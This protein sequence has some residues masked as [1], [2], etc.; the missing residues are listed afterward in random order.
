MKNKNLN[1]ILFVLLI[2][3]FGCI[4]IYKTVNEN[5][6]AAPVNLNT[7]L[8]VSFLDVGQADA[9]LIQDGQDNMLIDAGNTEDGPKLV[10]YLK[11]NGIDTFKYVVGTHAHEDHIGGMSD[12]VNNFTI[13]NYYMPDVLTTTKTFEDLLDALNNKNIKLQ[14]P[15][16]N[17]TFTLNNA[18]F[19]V[20]YV[21]TDSENLNNSSIVLKMTY[22]NMKFLFMGDATNTVEKAIINDDLAADVL[23]VGHHGSSTSSSQDFLNKVSPKYAVISVGKDNTYNLPSAKTITKLDNLNVKVYRTDELG[24]IIMQSDGNTID[25]TTINA[26]TNG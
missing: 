21:G 2:M 4:S 3:L 22:G 23:K 12:I 16:I 19:K 5:S 13:E 18:N 24:T 15:S 14:T 11:N 1:F 10:T 20:L 9:I 7:N 26:D 8:K 6:S 17:D 25:V